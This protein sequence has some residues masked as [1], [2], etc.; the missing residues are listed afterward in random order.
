MKLTLTAAALATVLAAPA[1]AQAPA[2]APNANAPAATTAPAGN[3]NMQAR[4]AGQTAAGGFLQTQTAQ[5]WRG[6]QLI[7]SSVHGPDNKSIG[8]IN[9]VIVGSDGNVRG[10]VIGVGGFL[11]I[12]E[13]DVAVPFR[14]LT[15]TRQA[16]DDDIERINV[17]YT[18]EQLEKAP[19]FAYYEAKG[20]S[21]AT[22]GTGATPARTNAP[23][24]T[25]PAG[26]GTAPA[27]PAR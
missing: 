20:N 19:A 18:K 15:V 21:A 13:K 27:T 23:A 24:G 12:G 16:N 6:S 4:P 5:E 2:T 8:E 1:F 26:S 17:S 14:D 7:G 11:G 22:T 3:N 10:V 9:D 25:A